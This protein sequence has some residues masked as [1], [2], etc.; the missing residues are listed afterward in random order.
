MLCLGR[1]TN[2]AVLNVKDP[3]FQS[4]SILVNG[5]VWRQLLFLRFGGGFGFGLFNIDGAAGVYCGGFSGVN[6]TV[7]LVGLCQLALVQKQAAKAIGLAEFE[8]RVHLDRVKGT[9]FHANLAAHAHR[10]VDVKGRRLKLEFP[11]EVRLFRFVF[12]NVNAL[13]R[14]FFFANSAGDATESLHGILAVV[15]EEG[16]V[17]GVFF[18]GNSLLWVFDRRQVVLGRAESPGKVLCRLEHSFDD[19]GACHLQKCLNPLRL[20][21]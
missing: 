13:G 17:A 5:F 3:V 6:A 8:F 14:A 16:K 20:P 4:L 12:L 9:Y 7:V 18:G 10:Y 11:D 15:N 21:F 1:Q 2:Q 19:A